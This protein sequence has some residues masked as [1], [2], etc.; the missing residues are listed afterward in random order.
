MLP[1][2][3]YRE[4]RFQEDHNGHH[5]YVNEDENGRFVLP[6]S[7]HPF[8]VMVVHE[9]GFFSKKNIQPEEQVVLQLE[10][11][12]SVKGNI[13]QFKTDTDLYVR[14]EA[15]R[16]NLKTDF[17]AA[18]GI[19]DSAKELL[20]KLT[21]GSSNPANKPVP[22]RINFNTSYNIDEKG[23]F[24]IPNLPSGRWWI[25]VSQKKPVNFGPGGS[26]GA[27]SLEPQAARE[28]KVKPGKQSTVTFSPL[29]VE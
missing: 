28:V 1:V 23:N 19:L 13:E 4:V 9:S 29:K 3:H 26:L 6:A 27:F 2:M 16:P 17:K 22:F 14:V 11:W 24:E 21:G 8:D 20:S 10:D 7:K 25:L 15:E 18:K 12:G 5:T